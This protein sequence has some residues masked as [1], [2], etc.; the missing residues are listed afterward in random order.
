MTEH[1]NTIN[2]TSMTISNVSISVF[3]TTS[4][5]S[6]MVEIT[7]SEAVGAVVGLSM[8]NELGCSLSLVLIEGVIVVE[9]LETFAGKMIMCV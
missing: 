5:F 3:C 9:S 2:T 1:N 8:L 7:G 6:S 4:S